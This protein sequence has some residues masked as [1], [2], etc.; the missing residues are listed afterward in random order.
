MSQTQTLQDKGMDYVSCLNALLTQDVDIVFIDDIPDQATA[1]TILDAARSC[2][3][4]AGLP[5]ER[6]EQAVDGL[7]VRG[8]E[9]WKIARSLLGI[10]NQQLLRRVCPTCRVAYPLRSEEL[11]QFGVSALS[12]SDT[13]VYTA[14]QRTQEERLTNANLCSS[15]GGT[16]YQGQNCRA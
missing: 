13:V 3:V 5:I 1:N 15:C 14:K 8:M 16:G 7:R 11:S 10:V 9:D 2:L 12:A 6:S 4:V